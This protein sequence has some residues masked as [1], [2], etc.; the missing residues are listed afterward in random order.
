MTYRLAAPTDLDSICSLISGAIAQ[1]ERDG[2][3]Q[4]DSIYPARDDFI[5]DISQKTLYIAEQEHRIAAVYVISQQCDGEYKKCRWSNPAKT[6]CIIHRFCV[7]PDFQN[8]GVG[9]QVL[10]HIENQAAGMGYESIRLDVF[11]LNPYALKLYMNSG[12]QERGFADWRKGRF[13]LMEK[14][15]KTID[16]I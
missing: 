4:W 12:Y 9:R 7:A 1:M 2:I 5:A 13:V 3:H 8:K 14:A 15:L 10:E 6:A 11:T 16:G